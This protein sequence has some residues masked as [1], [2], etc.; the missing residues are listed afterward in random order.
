ML[1]QIWL[2]LFGVVYH[3]GREATKGHYVAD[4]YHTGNH[5]T[6]LISHV[7]AYISYVYNYWMSNVDYAQSLITSI[8]TFFSQ[9]T[10]V[11]SIVMTVLSNQLQNN[12]WVRLK[13]HRLLIWDQLKSLDAILP[14]YIYLSHFYRLCSH[15]R[16][17]CPT[18]SSTGDLANTCNDNKL[19]KLFLFKTRRHN[20]RSGENCQMTSTTLSQHPPSELK[21]WFIFGHQLKA[22]HRNI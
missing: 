19:T 10:P 18:F 20:G 21:S 7:R 1:I 11:G 6:K 9:A 13:Y 17:V 12:W 2:R 8:H 14:W 15:H 5:N 3:N 16:I 4:V 22:K